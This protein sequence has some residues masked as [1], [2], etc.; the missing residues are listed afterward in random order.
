MPAECFTQYRDMEF[1]G[2]Q[3]RTFV[4]YDRYLTLLYHDYMTL[5][6]VGKRNHEAGEAHVFPAAF[7]PSSE[8]RTFRMQKLNP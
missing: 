6:P 5:P 7:I 4:D 8:Y 2:M 1:E 3:F